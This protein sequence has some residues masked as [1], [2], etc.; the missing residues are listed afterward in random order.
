MYTFE[1]P[2]A[3]STDESGTW[4]RVTA[5]GYATSRF[6]L[7]VS[8]PDLT[9]FGLSLAGRKMVFDDVVLPLTVANNG[10]T[11][12]VAYFGQDYVVVGKDDPA[13]P[14]VPSLATPQAGDSFAL[15]VQ[16]QG[17]EVFSDSLGTASDVTILP[18]TPKVGVPPIP[19]FILEGPISVSTGPQ[20]GKPIITGGVQVPTAIN[21]NVSE[22]ATSVGLPANIYP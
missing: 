20:P 9:S 17:S 10:A 8:P 19:S 21:V 11:R 14:F 3:Y 2:A 16:R 15:Y 5:P 4:T 6:R 13:D 7:Y 1:I 12:T 18:V 22:Q